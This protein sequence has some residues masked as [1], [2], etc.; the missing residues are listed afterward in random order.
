MINQQWLQTFLT[1]VEVGHFTQTAEKLYMTQPGVSQQIKK[2]EQH[3]GVALLNRFGKRFELTREGEA[4]YR[5]GCQRRQEEKQLFAE[6][7]F[8][9]AHK[10]ECRLAC[11]GAMA[12]FLYPHLLERQ[13]VFPELTVSIEAAPNYRIVE[14]LHENDIDLGIVTQPVPTADLEYESL[15]FE[16]LCLVLPRRYS[17]Q[18]P[19]FETLDGLG[20]V[21][22]PDGEHY[23][24]RLLRANFK[25]AYQGLKRIKKT[26]YINQLSQILIPVSAGLGF[27]VLPQTAIW[28]FSPQSSLYVPRLKISIQDELFLV[29]KRYRNLPKRY[30]WFINKI[31]ELIGEKLIV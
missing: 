30:D 18:L 8:D 3:V 19:R 21:D 11:S 6:L 20:F 12:T 16:A 4:L 10:G 5:F 24:D 25:D 26:G 14:R 29:R 7:Q 31:K 23:A 22:H 15:G 17:G 28:Q 1:L 2:L 13:K 9:D 27:T